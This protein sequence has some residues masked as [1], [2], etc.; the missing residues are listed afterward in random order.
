MK[1]KFLLAF[2]F[3]VLVIASFTVRAGEVHNVGTSEEFAEAIEVL[4]CGDTIRLTAN[5]EHEGPVSIYNAITIDRN[6]YILYLSADTQGR[7]STITVAYNGSIMLEG[8]GEFNVSNSSGTA[9]FS[10]TGI[11]MVNNVTSKGRDG[12]RGVSAM[13]GANVIVIGDVSGDSPI[14]AWGDVV[15]TVYGNV[16]V[17]GS[18]HLGVI[19]ERGA[20]I[21]IT[22]N[23][24][25]T[26]S[27]RDF[28]GAV[29]AR[30]E[31]SLITVRGN[32]IGFAGNGV[33]VHEDAHVRVYGS[34]GR[35][36]TA[37]QLRTGGSAFVEGNMYGSIMSIGDYN[38]LEFAGE[39]FELDSL[40]YVFSFTAGVRLHFN[41]YHIIC[42]HSINILQT[43]DTTPIIADGNT[44]VPLRFIAYTLGAQPSWKSETREITLI[45]DNESLTFAI[46]ELAYGMDMH[47]K[48]INDRT[49]VSLYFVEAFFSA[50]TRW[51]SN[52]QRI[53]ITWE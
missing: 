52:E 48:I 46:G 5:I 49:F 32:V 7:T 33:T 35:F 41:S 9:V 11:V 47:A 2:I 50:V 23:V 31:G 28:H 13:P 26:T 1:L 34:I 39:L 43:M 25:G 29:T 36:N 24:Y 15:V 16:T 40:P 14:G 4:E 53:E 12:S 3:A 42:A 37:L 22:G 51:T 20:N 18:W 45:Q 6:G 8:D 21:H 44:L 17:R 19:A 30:H 10:N 27:R 38:E